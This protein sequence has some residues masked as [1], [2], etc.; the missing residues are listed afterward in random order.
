MP[1]S[2]LLQCS[3]TDP[4]LRNERWY[5]SGNSTASDV[6]P[7]QTSFQKCTFPPLLHDMPPWLRI[8]HNP[9]IFLSKPH[10]QMG[11]VASKN[12][13]PNSTPHI[14]LQWFSSIGYSSPRQCTTTIY[15]FIT[16]S[17]HIRSPPW[18]IVMRTSGLSRSF[19][20]TKDGTGGSHPCYCF[21]SI[22]LFYLL[23]PS[24]LFEGNFTLVTY[25]VVFWL[26]YVV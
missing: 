9:C 23:F 25:L 24:T 2:S 12:P 4:S 8:D 7:H 26:F 21:I 3:W 10:N 1:P 11:H 6:F 5:K 16:F 22:F 17:G 13:N 18:S 15:S 20:S 14:S 19:R